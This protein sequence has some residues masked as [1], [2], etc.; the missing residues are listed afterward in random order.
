M[1]LLNHT[2]SPGAKMDSAANKLRS[3]TIRDY[4]DKENKRRHTLKELTTNIENPAPM[5]HFE[6][7]KDFNKRN[8]STTLLRIANGP[9]W[10]QQTRKWSH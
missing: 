5:A 7:R 1:S 8:F 4:E 10:C 9:E 3:L 6:L 2:Y